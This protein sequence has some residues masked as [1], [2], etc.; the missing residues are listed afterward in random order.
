MLVKLVWEWSDL[1]KLNSLVSWVV[2][3]LWL[4]EFLEIKTTNDDS[5]KASLEI[6]EIPA[7]CIE[8]DSIDFRDVIFQWQIPEKSELESMFMS[9][10]WW[11]EAW[12]WGCSTCSDDASTCWSTCG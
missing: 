7:L 11:W 5:Y 8:E 10:I 2:E 4:S 6:T 9:I 1:N 12:W 3:D